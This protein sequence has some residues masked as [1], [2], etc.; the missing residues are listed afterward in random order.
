MARPRLTPNIPMSAEML[1]SQTK[2]EANRKRRSRRFKT[3]CPQY[4]EDANTPMDDHHI[5]HK[6][7]HDG[8]VFGVYGLDDWVT[9]T[10]MRNAIEAD[11]NTLAMDGTW[12][13]PANWVLHEWVMTK[14]KRF[15]FMST[16][17]VLM[18]MDFGLVEV[19]V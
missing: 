9:N 2:R 7:G 17:R 19:C 6:T 14:T 16:S 15:N 12:L 13:V 8:V 11:Q 10:H 4:A 5:M 3:N 1:A 18:F